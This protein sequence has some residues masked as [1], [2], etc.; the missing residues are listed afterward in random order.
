MHLENKI[1]TDKPCVFVTLHH[2]GE[3]HAMSL[4][5]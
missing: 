5:T 2:A 3:V 1:K 4:A